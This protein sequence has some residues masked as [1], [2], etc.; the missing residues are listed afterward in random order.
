[1]HS[2]QLLSPEQWK[3][4]KEIRLEALRKSPNSF[5]STFEI[6][7]FF[8]Q[9]DWINKL[10]N[11]KD[12][13]LV[14]LSDNFKP[15]GLII[16]KP[17]QEQV[18]IFGTYVNPTFRGRGIASDLMHAVIEYAIKKCFS[19]IILDVYDQ[20]TPAIELYKRKGFIF[21][22]V[23]TTLPS[24]RKHIIKHQMLLNL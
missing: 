18:G 4:F 16:L 2:I 8:T 1:M 6:E 23:K 24:P 13:H 15:I 10:K 3:I 5:G 12:L 22:G 14:A 11:T 21:T 17:Y 20:N 7:S 19:E 9:N